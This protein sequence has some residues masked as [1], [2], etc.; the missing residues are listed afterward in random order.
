MA[1]QPGCAALGVSALVALDESFGWRRHAAGAATLWF[2]GHLDAID[3]ERLAADAASWWIAPSA[4]A[5]GDWAASLDGHFALVVERP[6]WIGLAV[7]RVRSIPLFIA[8]SGERIALGADA[9][10]LAERLGLEAIDADAALAIAMAG[11]TV[12]RDVLVRGIEALLPGEVVVV[13]SD[14]PRPHR[15]AAYRPW[16]ILDRG[17]ER[18]RDGLVGAIDEA[19]D[20]LVAGTRGRTIAVPLSAGLD[21][22]LVA[23][24]LRHRGIR[25]VR[26]FAY[27]LSDNHEARASRAIA[28]R[29]GYPWT[30]VPVTRAAQR[31]LFASERHRAYLRFADSLTAVPFRQDMLAIET[32]TGTGWMPR[33][34]V[35]VNGNSGDFISGNHIVPSLRAPPP[36]PDANARRRRLL[37]ALLDKH[38]ALWRALATPD[39]RARMARRI[40]V[41]WSD[42]GAELGDPGADHGLFEAIEFQDRQAKYVIAGQR[43]YEF[44]GLDWR[45]PLWDRALLGFWESAPLSAKAGQRLWR[46]TLAAL[47][48]GGVWRPMDWP[49]PLAPAWVRPLRLAARG[50]AAPLGRE[51][52]HAIDRHLFGPLTDVLANAAVVPYGCAVLDRRGARHA[53]AWFAED[54]L[55]DKGLGFDGTPAVNP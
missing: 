12:G 25:D 2:K 29:L 4:E 14:G 6:D 19:I 8:R 9:P 26:L 55:A 50:I 22:R 24:A 49:R 43:I 13:A 39:N 18:L 54:Y 30:F 51:R 1:A 11:Y 40:E 20:R 5:F 23:S 48:W 45:L 44:L 28:E 52:W 38:F 34:A 31:D 33:D 15:Y 17:D 27:G 42:L 21:S 41:A 32:L 16:R 46:E 53:V 47:D 35:I 7:D 10:A 3:P 37:E 36:G